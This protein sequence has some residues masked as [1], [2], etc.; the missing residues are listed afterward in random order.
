MS[1]IENAVEAVRA[2]PPRWG[3]PPG[4]QFS[5][6]RAAWVHRNLRVEQVRNLDLAEQAARAVRMSRDSPT[7]ALRALEAAKALADADLAD[8]AGVSFPPLVVH[9][10]EWQGIIAK[11]LKDPDKIDAQAVEGHLA[12][13]TAAVAKLKDN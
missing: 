12:A 9:L 6:A 7:D 11:L 3:T 1:E 8:R 13:W 2:Y 5:E 4:T 10:K